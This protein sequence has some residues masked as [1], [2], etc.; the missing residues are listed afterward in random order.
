MARVYVKSRDTM[1]EGDD[2][3][4]KLLRTIGVRYERWT[5]TAPVDPDADA[6][7]ILKAYQPEVER[8]KASGGYLTA[9]V[10]A[11]NPT[12]P[13]LPAILGKFRPEHT[14]DDDEVRFCVKGRG[15]FHLH[16]AGGA[17]VAVEMAPGDLISV[18][19]GMMHWFDLAGEQTIRCIRLFKD[20]SGWTPKYTESRLEQEFEPQVFD[21]RKPRAAGAN[22]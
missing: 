22:A 9:D 18:P 14:H 20:A 7:A 19:A 12:T 5:L 16:P 17:V 8:L 6:E 11:L 13:N 1:L 15:V 21:R 4:K 3:I 2:E 10:I